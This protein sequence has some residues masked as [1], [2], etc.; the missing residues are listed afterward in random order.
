MVSVW[1]LDVLIVEFLL[2]LNHSSVEMSFVF[3][4]L[5][6]VFASTV[7]SI[8]FVDYLRV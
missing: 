8:G 1:T 6:S 5:W 2:L 4:R 7:L 3:A